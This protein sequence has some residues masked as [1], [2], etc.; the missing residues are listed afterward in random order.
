L[1]TPFSK[2]VAE[3]L[4][5]STATPAE[6]APD[7][8]F[9]TLDGKYVSL[10]DLKGKVVL[11]DFWATWCGPCRDSV[12]HLRNLSRKMKDAPFVIVG[13]SVDHDKDALLAFVEAERMNWPQY[14]DKRRELAQL[15]NVRGYPTYILIDHQGSIVFEFKGWGQGVGPIIDAQVAKAIRN[16]MKAPKASSIGGR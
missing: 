13:L 11:L 12:P 15:Y 3:P 7:F 8:F 9:I 6:T 14:W 2:P 5:A 10:E 16:A 4:E 1:L